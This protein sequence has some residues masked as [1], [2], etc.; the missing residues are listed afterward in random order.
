M[1]RQV[2]VSFLSGLTIFLPSPLKNPPF[3]LRLL[4]S[5]LDWSVYVHLPA[6]KGNGLFKKICRREDAPMF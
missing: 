3:L 5:L 1:R 2:S 6:D 4:S